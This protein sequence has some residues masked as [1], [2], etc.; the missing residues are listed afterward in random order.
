[1]TTQALLAYFFLNT[2]C[3]SIESAIKIVDEVHESSPH[4]CI[5]F[6]GYDFSQNSIAMVE[7]ID[8]H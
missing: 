1:M 5:T 3:G 7:Y 2:A 6:N 8:L 4:R